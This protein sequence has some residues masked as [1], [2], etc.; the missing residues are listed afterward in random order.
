MV[1]ALIPHFIHQQYQANR[2]KGEFR[3][4]AMFVDLSGFTTLTETLMQYHKEGAEILTETLNQIFSPLVTYLYTHGGFIVNFAGDGFMALFP[5]RRAQAPLHAVQTAFFINQFLAARGRVQTRYGKFELGLKI[6]LSAGQV[7]WGILGQVERLTYFFRGEAIDACAQAEQQAAKGEIIADDKLLSLLQSS[8]E[9]T[10]LEVPGFYRLTAT[11]LNLV[12]KSSPFHEFSRTD[13]TPFVMDEVIDLTTPAEFRDVCAIFISFDRPENDRV[14]NEL[15]SAIIDLLTSYRGYFNRVSFGDK[16]GVILVLF[17]APVAYENNLERAADFLLSLNRQPLRLNWR[18]GLTF[19]SAY[20]GV[21]GG[22]ERC[23]Y[24]AMGDVVNLSARLMTNAAWGE[25]WCNAVVYERLKEAYHLAELGIHRFKGK[26][27]PI[28]VYQLLAK[29]EFVEA[30]FHTGQMVGRAAELDQLAQAV[31]PIF[32]GRFAGLIYIYGEAGIGKSRLVYEFRQFLA[33][34]QRFTWLHCPA[35]EILQQ[36]LNPFKHM[37][38]GYFEQVSEATPEENKARFEAVLAALSQNLPGVHPETEAIRT[39]LE[40]SQS[41]LGALVNLYW[42]GSLYEQLDP[43]LRFDNTL[44]ALK[45]LVKA[46]TL[47]QPVII[48]LD[49]AHWLDRDSG[50]LVKLLTRNVAAFP[51]VL[52]CTGRY[53]DDGSKSKLSVDEA[54]GQSEIDL[55]Y[56]DLTGAQVL[57]EQML[58][59]QVTAELIH[60]LVEKTNGNPFFIEQLLLDLQERGL[61][62]T[63]EHQGHLRYRLSSFRS[64]DVPTTI[65]AVLISRLDRLSAAVKQVVQ[66]ASVLGREFETLVLS[67][68]LREDSQLERRLR[69]AEAEQIWSTLSEIRYIFKHALLRDSAYDMQLRARLRELHQ[70]AGESFEQ[71][72]AADL[73]RYYPDLAYHYEKAENAAKAVIYLEK[74]GDYAK[75][76][77]Q[78]EAAFAFY[79]RLLNY[80]LPD[81]AR[82]AIYGKKGEILNL[83]GQWDLAVTMLT[84]GLAGAEIGH[85]LSR[86]AELKITLGDVLRRRGDY[87]LALQ[88]LEE[89][90]T[91]AG[92]RQDKKTLGRILS[93]M[94]GVYKYKLEMEQSLTLYEQALALGQEVGDKQGVAVAVAGVATGYSMGRNDSETGLAYN[95]QAIPMFE[96]LGDKMGLIYPLFNAG[97]AYFS[98]GEYEQALAFFQRTVTECVEIGDREGIWFAYHYLGWIYLSLGQAE[99]ALPYLL[100]SLRLRAEMGQTGIPQETN[101]YL[102]IAYV[103][104]GQEV[105]AL[106]AALRHFQHIEQ[107]GRDVEYGQGHLAVA[108]V[109]ANEYSWGRNGSSSAVL[110]EALAQISQLAQLPAEPAAYFTHAITAAGSGPI[111]YPETLIPALYCYGRYLY[112]NK[113]QVDEGRQQVAA[114]KQQA[115]HFKMKGELR[116]VEQVCTELGIDFEQ[117]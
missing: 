92:V 88:H 117:I 99:Q 79:D 104:L 66:T 61:L 62:L 73:S 96:E 93:I 71:L 37:L 51:F 9:S 111:I 44:A 4:V 10:P 15:V 74:A 114:A 17:G 26:R 107:T 19:G 50:E 110:V 11:S 82:A 98:L 59:G 56:L 58:P 33:S 39:E 70:L 87:E 47:R 20:A 52:I 83:T 68:M 108:L 91:T 102:A 34:Q 40:R 7:R 16:G 41:L 90:R 12:P 3:A 89:A 1:R 103:R 54:V 113:G 28:L 45:N 86:L 76:N 115:L 24:T 21:M 81:P 100:E 65:N 75:E 57:A 2:S 109:L 105:E 46:E 64:E 95:L 72:Y 5:M 80:T 29:K 35:E 112:L 48:E 49:D 23:E 63:E 42:P 55:N 84:E 43:R 78:N 8:V 36:P 38:R 97:A 69:Q 13:L 77:Y 30:S 94:A 27:E 22:L 32:H 60:F 106:Q 116:Q 85:D 14:L 6:G 101:P 18:A 31:Q 67:Q 25:L 53:R